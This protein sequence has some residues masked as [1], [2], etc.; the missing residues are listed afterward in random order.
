V[1]VLSG[2]FRRFII[3]SGDVELTDIPDGVRGPKD[4]LFRPIG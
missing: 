2:F 1:R 3:L 4:S